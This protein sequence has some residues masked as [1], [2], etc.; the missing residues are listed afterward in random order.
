MATKATIQVFESSVSPKV[1]AEFNT[2][3]A[4]E[5]WNKEHN[6]NA[7]QVAVNDCVLLGWDELYDFV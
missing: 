1:I 6:V 2:I 5:E 3:E 7:D 4:L